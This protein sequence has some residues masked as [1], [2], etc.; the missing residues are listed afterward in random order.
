[1]QKTSQCKNCYYLNTSGIKGVGYE[2]TTGLS[3]SIIGKTAEELKS[4][5]QTLGDAYEQNNNLNEGY[6][7]LKENK[8]IK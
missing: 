4:L 2:E 7:Y 8:P 6:P 3:D 5:A 1:M